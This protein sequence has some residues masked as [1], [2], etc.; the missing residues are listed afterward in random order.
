MRTSIKILKEFLT[1]P[2][3]K[4]IRE[5]AQAINADYKITHTATTRLIQKNIL[6]TTTVGAS[7]LCQRNTNYWGAEIY[8]AEHERTQKKLT[9]RNLAE[10]TK[11]ITKNTPTTFYVAILFGSY[12]NNT[13]NKHSDID[14]LFI[15]NQEEFEKT[16][17]QTLQTLPQNIHAITLTQKEY[18]RMKNNPEKTVVTEATKNYIILHGIEAY[19]QL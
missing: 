17:Q 15:T 13:Q 14:I 18:T 1:N 19:H 4:T 3:P 16:I 7:T 5:I 12:A 8:Q 9:N 11:H 6:T 10:I 2:H